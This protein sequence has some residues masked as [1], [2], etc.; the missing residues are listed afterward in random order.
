MASYVRAVVEVLEDI[1]VQFKLAT[2][3]GE[4]AEV[5]RKIKRMGRRMRNKMGRPLEDCG[6]RR[7]LGGRIITKKRL[8]RQRKT[9]RWSRLRWA[10]RESSIATGAIIRRRS[11]IA[12]RLTLLL[13]LRRNI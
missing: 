12:T 3:G 6:N 11:R 13:P 10:G 9:S 4:P 7:S 8:L 5:P 2:T 1:A